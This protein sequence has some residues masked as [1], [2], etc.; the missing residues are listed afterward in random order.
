MADSE[1]D[2][3][4]EKKSSNKLKI[5]LAAVVLLLVVAGTLYFTGVFSSDESQDV[6]ADAEVVEES[7][8]DADIESID[9][10]HPLEPAFIV[11]FQKGQ[12]AKLLQ[13]GITVLANSELAVEALKLHAPMI[14]NNLLMLLNEQEPDKLRTRAGKEVIQASVLEEIQKVVD[15]HIGGQGIEDVFFTEF[16]MQ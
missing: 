3:G 8:D 2:L 10:Y 13:V 9:I 4:E 1:T 16:V 14:R 15:K 6:D 11:N 12:S 5:I 7:T